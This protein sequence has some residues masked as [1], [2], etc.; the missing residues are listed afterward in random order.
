MRWLNLLTTLSRITWCWL[1]CDRRT[2]E[3]PLGRKQ[4]HNTLSAETWIYTF[5]LG[6]IY[7]HMPDLCY[8]VAALVFSS[9]GHRQFSRV[10]RL[11]WV[12]CC[13]QHTTTTMWNPT[14]TR[15][16]RT[17]I[18]LPSWLQCGIW[19]TSERSQGCCAVTEAKCA[20]SPALIAAWDVHSP[21]SVITSEV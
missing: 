7:K 19:G 5:T 13:R 8:D 11:F 18:K 17:M 2:C 9:M 16:E 14:E 20:D 3:K 21:Q 15:G 12:A 10:S 6:L 1:S 4:A